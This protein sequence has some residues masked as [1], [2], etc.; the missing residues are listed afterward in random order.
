MKRYR[1]LYILNE[2]DKFMIEKAKRPS[3]KDVAKLAGVSITTVSQILN[4]K[5]ERFPRDT[6]EKVIAAK[7]QLGYIP[8]KSAQKLRGTAKPLIGVLVPSLRNP[9]F[10]DLMQSMEEHANNQ[11]ELIFQAAKDA[12]F[13]VNIE[14]LV[15]RGVNGL[16]IARTVERAEE[17][18]TFLKQ[19]GV[20]VTVLDQ[21]DDTGLADVLT[22]DDYHGGQLVGD[23]LVNQGHQSVALILPDIVTNNMQ[24]R[25]DGF[26]EQWVTET[27][28]LF[29]IKTALSK[30]GGLAVSAK[31]AQL[32]E[33]G[34]TAAFTL[35]DELGIGLSR[36]LRNIGVKIPTELSIIG[37]DNTD[38]S[39]FVNPALTTVTQPVWQL[40]QRALDMVMDRLKHPNMPYQAE[41]LPVIRLVERESTQALTN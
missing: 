20:A 8:N 32:I 21:A 31:V 40:G 28:Q 38:F 9:F 37:Y 18:F 11:V 23:F 1:C 26:K 33:S 4:H 19:H 10:A 34:V 35:N 30:H 36:G 12:D 6:I 14:N 41:Q 39:E 27:R 2:R 5:S 3:I 15:E 24:R 22:T 13:K 7:T 16:V 17:T 29:E 25:I